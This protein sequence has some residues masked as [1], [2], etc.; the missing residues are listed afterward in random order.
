MASLGARRCDP[1]PS[2]EA[3]PE[4]SYATEDLEKWAETVNMRGLAL[5]HFGSEFLEGSTT[6]CSLSSRVYERVKHFRWISARPRPILLAGAG[7]FAVAAKHTSTR[8]ATV[9]AVV[10]L[11]VLLVPARVRAETSRGLPHCALLARSTPLGTAI[12]GPSALV[13][14]PAFAQTCSSAAGR[15]TGAGWWA[16]RQ[17]VSAADALAPDA[18]VVTQCC[19]GW[20]QYPWIETCATPPARRGCGFCFW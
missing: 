16:S 7:G 3:L 19:S 10:A 11:A 15:C 14:M 8:A 1:L 4:K 5:A 9:C 6:K 17:C 2:D 20:F 12:L 13:A 18:L